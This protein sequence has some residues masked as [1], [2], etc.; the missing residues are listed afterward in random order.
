MKV[1]ELLHIFG[2]SLFAF[3]EKLRVGVGSCCNAR[4]TFIISFLGC[5]SSKLVI[6]TI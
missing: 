5:L 3:S 1:R 2:E 6:K 4:D